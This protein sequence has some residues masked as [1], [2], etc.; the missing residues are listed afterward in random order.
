M[1]R[2]LAAVSLFLALG[3]CPLRAGALPEEP[4]TQGEA[5]ELRRILEELR[6]RVEALEAA[7]PARSEAEEVRKL[8]GEAEKRIVALEERHSAILLYRPCRNTPRLLRTAPRK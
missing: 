7:G 8:L 5:A 4:P 1:F 6:H 3:A 2:R